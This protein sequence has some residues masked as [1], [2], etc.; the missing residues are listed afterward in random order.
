LLE[1]FSNNDSE[2]RI[3]VLDS[4]NHDLNDKELI[5]LLNQANVQHKQYPSEIFIGEKICDGLNSVETPYSV[6]CADDDFLIP[7]ALIKCCNYL[8]RNQDYVSAH[9]VYFFHNTSSDE[10]DK[11][12]SWNVLFPLS[13]SNKRVSP[14]ARLKYFYPNNY[15][16]Y[17]MYAVH[18]TKN[19]KDIWRITKEHTSDWGWVEL[20][21]S[22]LSI[23]QGKS[24]KLFIP[25]ASRQTNIT[26]GFDGLRTMQ[27]YT[28]EKN[29]YAFEAIALELEKVSPDSKDDYRKI[30]SVLHDKYLYNLKNPVVLYKNKLTYYTK[31]PYE[32]L[33]RV[34]SILIKL[35]I[36]STR[37]AESLKVIHKT[38]L[39]NYLSDD[40]I[41][42]S[43]ALYKDGFD[44]KDDQ[45]IT[46]ETLTIVI[47]TFNRYPY[48]KRLMNYF[49]SLESSLNLMILDSS[50]DEVNDA[51]LNEA[52]K[53]DNIQWKKFPPDTL[54][55]EKISKGIKDIQSRYT[56]I[57]A[58]DDFLI[59][60]TLN[61][62]C[63]FL[64]RHPDYIS[65]HGIYVNHKYD[66]S[67]NQEVIWEVM[68]STSRSNTNVS[69][70]SR[71]KKFLPN[72]YSSY[73][74]YAVHRTK[75]LINIWESTNTN[76]NE[77]GWEENFPACASI[78]QGKSKKLFSVYASREV[79]DPISYKDFRI[80][81][82]Y[83]KEQNKLAI[84]ALSIML[85]NVSSKNIDQSKKMIKKQFRKY[86]DRVREKSQ[87]R[88]YS[89]RL[90][91]Y[92][93]NKNLILKRMMS[94]FLKQIIILF[95][96][97]GDLKDIHH[98]IKNTV[99]P[100]S[101]LK[102]SREMLSAQSPT[103]RDDI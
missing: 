84:D 86:L 11:T 83:S 48:L 56:V 57:S 79:N 68:Y 74:M 88:I 50:S 87:E 73:P 54:P 89:N 46:K 55:R 47:I 41:T 34:S 97:N 9:G 43:R 15:S 70:Y 31:N 58:D 6:L 26:S 65:A 61:L 95:L 38:L 42:E 66:V 69:S 1:Y 51:E 59:P 96:N 98:V 32:L 14:L 10:A 39:F 71:L 20:L 81:E 94:Y 49:N 13:R 23:I 33:I 19:L 80:N 92:Y 63:D 78:I 27:M 12:I 7:A 64:N 8:D 93:S 36:I 28:E 29:Q 40:P 45:H 17:P 52:L 100:R 75:N 85:N 62:A 53:R 5:Q 77:W 102:R 4:S 35:L 37:Q 99:I 76:V 16:S 44:T 67:E 25:Y 21:S 82:K 22:C 30:I 101:L 103:L 72:N 3:I 91:Y 24:K 18:R 60:P 2:F 90:H